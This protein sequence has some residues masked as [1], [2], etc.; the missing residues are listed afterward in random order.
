[1]KKVKIYLIIIGFGILFVSCDSRTTQDLEGEITNPTYAKNIKPIID[2][3][4]VRCHSQTGQQ[5]F[6]DL[7]TY[8][9][10]K[11]AQDGTNTDKLLCSL[12]GAYCTDDRMPK[13]DAPLSNGSIKTIENWINNNYPQ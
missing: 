9:N 3:K 5:E 10:V 13:S 6:P 2:A 7:D 8:Q 1:M 4:C 11:W 12:K